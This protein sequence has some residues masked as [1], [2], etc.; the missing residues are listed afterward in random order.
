MKIKITFPTHTVTTNDL[1]EREAL[2]AAIELLSDILRQKIASR[3][4]LTYSEL[5]KALRDGVTL[6]PTN[7]VNFTALC[8]VP[9]SGRWRLEPAWSLI[10]VDDEVPVNFFTMDEVL[11]YVVRNHLYFIP[12]DDGRVID[13]PQYLEPEP[14]TD[15]VKA[16]N[17]E[18]H[19]RPKLGL[20]SLRSVDPTIPEDVQLRDVRDGRGWLISHLINKQAFFKW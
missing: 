1:P 20:V 15:E 7:S 11:Q 13:R 18:S 19:I 3:E 4:N 2:N 12:Q 14:E 6:Q 9:G 8:R 17:E 5:H 16:Y 10:R